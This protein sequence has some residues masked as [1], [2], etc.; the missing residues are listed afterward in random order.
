MFQQMKAVSDSVPALFLFDKYHRI[1]RSIKIFRKRSNSVVG[2]RPEQIQYD[3]D[4]L[5]VVSC[6]FNATNSDDRTKNF[7]V[8]IEG[9]KK[10]GVRLLVVEVAYPGQDF[11]FG[12]D[13]ETIQL[14]AQD[15]MFEGSQWGFK[16]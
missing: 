7:R 11:C 8:F 13:V 4:K 2:I 1:K 5:A 15:V 10:S 14:R 16:I 6:F 3:R 9:I 12:E